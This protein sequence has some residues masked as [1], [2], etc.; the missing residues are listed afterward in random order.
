MKGINMNKIAIITGATSGF[1][2][3]T[4]KL[5]ASNNYNLIITGRRNQILNDFKLDL[6]STYNIAV[7]ALNFDVRNQKDVAK[8]I[9]SIPHE[10]RNIDVL[11][12][13]AGLA[14]GL[15]HIQ[16][17]NIDDWDK[18]LD[19]NVKGLLYVT[20]EVVQFMIQQ[21]KGHIVNI[22]SIAGH[23][24]YEKGNVYCAS[25]H[26]VEA[27][28]KSMRIDLVKHDIKV[29]S[30][31]PGMAETEF[32]I[33]RFHGNTEAAKKVYEGFTP[34][35]AEDIADAILY[36]ITRPQHVCINEMLIMP[37]NQASA[38]VVNRK[39]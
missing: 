20:R 21:K 22:S 23:E 27:L 14:S 4:A 24:V 31:A 36:V 10:W 39:V 11:V 5:L 15:S 34:L 28:T 7:L 29:T 30:I 19:T 12:N 2:M 3:A 37:T 26:A 9:A 6:E 13:N 18:M 35:L 1:G 16:D 32:S 38:A 25:K 17:G 33:V 8:A